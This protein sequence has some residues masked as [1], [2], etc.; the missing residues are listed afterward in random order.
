MAK[1]H[2]QQ[3]AVKTRRMRD[4]QISAVRFSFLTSQA[5]HDLS[6]LFKTATET[7]FHYGNTLHD[8]IT[9]G[10]SGTFFS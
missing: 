3:Q 2:W 6:C 9:V 4:M 8:L 1:H 7:I 10:P 5:K